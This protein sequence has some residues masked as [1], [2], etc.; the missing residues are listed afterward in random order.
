M[1]E[2]LDTAESPARSAKAG[3]PEAGLYNDADPFSGTAGMTKADTPTLRA[4]ALLEHLVNSDGPV[5]L[6]DIAQDVAL[7]KASLHRMLAS[8]EAGGLVIREPARRTRT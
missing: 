3:R 7:P 6:A 5:S 1:S 8:L 4:F 2:P